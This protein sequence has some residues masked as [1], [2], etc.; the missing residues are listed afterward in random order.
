MEIQTC[1]EINVAGGLVT[2]FR[3]RVEINLDPEYR[4]E[5][6]LDS[7]QEIK[8]GSAIARCPAALGEHDAGPHRWQWVH[9]GSRADPLDT[10]DPSAVLLRLIGT[11]GHHTSNA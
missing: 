8:T 5:I 3:N 10:D 1:P 7:H 9:C 6:A 11:E 4:T 2:Y